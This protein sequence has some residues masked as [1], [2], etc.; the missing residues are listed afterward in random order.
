MSAER[1]DVL[2]PPTIDPSGPDSIADIASFTGLDEY[3]DRE[4]LLADAD[5]FDAIVVRVTELSADL[6][7]AATDLKVISKH[8]AGVDNVDIEAASRNGVAVCNTPGVNARS[9]AEHAIGLVLAVRKSL[10]PADEEVRSGGWERHRFENRE[11]AADALGL[12]GFG[13]IAREV[14]AI[15]RGFEMTCLTY[16]PFVAAEET[17]A[18]VEMVE[19]KSELFERAD[20]VSVHTPLTP[21]TRD[22]VSSAEL[23]ALGPDGVV[24][25]TSRGGV[26][27]EAALVDA[28][29]R[30]AIAGAGIDVFAAEPPDAS[31]PLFDHRN[32]VLTPHVG[33][34]TREALERMSRRAAANVRTVY[35]G[36]LPESTLNADAL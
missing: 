3:P 24:V 14:A 25:N 28:L 17:P 7:D 5:R 29:E 4:A 36:D 15:G 2:L 26:V 16:D 20:A 27:D 10:L 33:G 9:V 21:E 1:W 23:D 34:V 13:D 18:H 12:L 19:T 6:I 30:D 31:H 32:A 35:E 11:L 22:A 8:G